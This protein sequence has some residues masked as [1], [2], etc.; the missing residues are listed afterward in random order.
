MD[1][2]TGINADT[3]EAISE[4]YVRADITCTFAYPKPGLLQGKGEFAAG[5]VEVLDIG[6]GEV[7]VSPASVLG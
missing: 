2:P 7:G 4:N 1:I 3:G 6:F 5:K